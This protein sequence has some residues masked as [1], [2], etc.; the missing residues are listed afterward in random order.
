MCCVCLCL[1]AD[2]VLSWQVWLLEMNCNPALHTNCEVLKDV[3]PGTVAEALGQFS[4]AHISYMLNTAGF[5]TAL[6]Y[7]LT[8]LSP[9]IPDLS[10]EIFHK[11]R[12]RRPLFP[13]TSQRD[14]VLLYNGAGSPEKTS[15]RVSTQKNAKTSP[16]SCTSKSKFLT[17]TADPTVGI[18][19]N[20]SPPKE[21]LKS[22]DS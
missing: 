19:R 4:D 7:L 1:Q 2:R 20:C 18:K 15:S 21:G 5:S 11:C 22:E 3:V 12:L 10:L 9:L 13:L 14:F 8:L 16:K 17:L 6:C